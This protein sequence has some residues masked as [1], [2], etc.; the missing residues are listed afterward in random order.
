LGPGPV[1]TLA[2][3]YLPQGY[4]AHDPTLLPSYS[5]LFAVCHRSG[6]YSWSGKG[7]PDGHQPDPPL[8][9]LGDVGLRPGATEGKDGEDS[10][11]RRLGDGKKR[12]RLGEG[13]KGRVDLPIIGPEDS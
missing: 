8:P 12:G 6:K 10:G 11:T 7:L 4:L 9:S 3:L 2:G 13:E 5:H 1:N